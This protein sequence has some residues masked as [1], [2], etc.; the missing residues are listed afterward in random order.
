MGQQKR[1]ALSNPAPRALPPKKRIRGAL[2]ERAAHPLSKRAVIA[3][4]RPV[5]QRK[6]KLIE[7]EADVVLPPKKRCFATAHIY[8][9]IAPSVSSRSGIPPTA[10]VVKSALDDAC[11]THPL[12]T[13]G[14]LAVQDVKVDTIDDVVKDVELADTAN[15]EVVPCE[16]GVQV[17][18]TPTRKRARG[19]ASKAKSTA[20]KPRKAAADASVA[21]PRRVATKVSVDTQESDTC[22]PLRQLTKAEDASVT[23]ALKHSQDDMVIVGGDMVTGRDDT[24]I[25]GENLNS[26][27]GGRL[28][29][30]LDTVTID[31]YTN[32][33]IKRQESVAN[34]EHEKKVFFFHSSFYSMEMSGNATKQNF[35]RYLRDQK[36]DDLMAY[37]K[38]VMP[39]NSKSHWLLIVID[40]D[41]GTIAAID[42]KHNHGIEH[43][44]IMTEVSEM[45][46]DYA[47]GRLESSALESFELSVPEVPQQTNNYDCGVFA[48]VAANCVAS[49]TPFCY[50]PRQMRKYRRLICAQILSGTLDASR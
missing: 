17:R 29:G 24:P 25:M 38:L 19:K 43:V 1:I 26:L 14:G 21:P 22:G 35:A 42:S 20:K 44:A 10:L 15:N 47:S 4:P 7:P 18:A 9:T 6:R 48:C 39:V 5:L 31:A 37:N 50:S 23:K 16:I 32:L 28:N 45:L 12:L 40:L 36:V 2:C 27:V 34:A 33:V 49:N 3:A 41:N 46:R 30:W 13:T 11:A 8:E